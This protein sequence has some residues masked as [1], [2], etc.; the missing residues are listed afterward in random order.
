MVGE[1]GT[2][3]GGSMSEFLYRHKIASGLVLIWTIAL[4]SWV[5]YQVFVDI[6]KITM[7]AAGAYATLFG[8]PAISVG[9]WKWR[10]GGDK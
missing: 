10:N 4:V 3:K 6:T 1:S 7:Q 2:T 9:L 8:L 5:T